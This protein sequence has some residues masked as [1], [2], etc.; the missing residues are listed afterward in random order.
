[1]VAKTRGRPKKTENNLK[2]KKIPAEVRKKME[3]TK[4]KLKNIR[5]S[6]K[7]IKDIEIWKEAWECSGTV[8]HAAKYLGVGLSSLYEFLQQEELKEADGIASEFMEAKR[9]VERKRQQ[10]IFNSFQ[11][12]VAERSEKSV[13][14][15]IKEVCGFNANAKAIEIKNKE[16]QLRLK[17]FDLKQKSHNAKIHEFILKIAHNLKK[18]GE[19]VDTIKKVITKIAEEDGLFSEITEK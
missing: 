1:M 13:L 8:K 2:N 3:E 11:E 15:G 9:D 4:E 17:E 19:S 10:V 18:N 5:E 7:T 16:Y 14:T 6:R 12:L